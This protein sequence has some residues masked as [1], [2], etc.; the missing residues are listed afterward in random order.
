MGADGNLGPQ[1]WTKRRAST[2]FLRV[3]AYDWPRVR[4]GLKTEF[5]T[6]GAKSDLDYV[7]PPIPVC[8]YSI[9]R[10]GYDSQLMVVEKRW[11]EPLAAIS[12]ESLAR[13]GFKTLAEFRAYWCHREKRRFPPTRMANVYQ[14]RPFDPLADQTYFAN[15]IFERLYGQFLDDN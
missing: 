4:R 15:L 1:P 10:L 5:R 9:N 11:R 2:L 12:E 3:P 14:V 13:E 7:E 6:S 8:A